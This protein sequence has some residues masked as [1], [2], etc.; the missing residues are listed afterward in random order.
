MEL[1]S[2]AKCTS[3]CSFSLSLHFKHFTWDVIASRDVTGFS[4]LMV[5]VSSS[6]DGSMLSSSR[7]G[8]CSLVGEGSV[9]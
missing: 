5:H 4:S 3:N 8:S 9:S 1:F 2:C 7:I 6:R